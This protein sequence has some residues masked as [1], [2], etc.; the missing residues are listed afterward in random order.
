M[1]KETSS[2]QIKKKSA[3]SFRVLKLAP[4]DLSRS[5]DPLL[6]LS[7]ILLLG[8]VGPVVAGLGIPYVLFFIPKACKNSRRRRRVCI[9]SPRLESCHVLRD[10]RPGETKHA[11]GEYDGTEKGSRIHPDKSKRCL[12]QNVPR[13]RSQ[14]GRLGHPGADQ[15]RRRR[16]LQGLAR[17]PPGK[18]PRPEISDQF[19]AREN[20][21]RTS[22]SAR[23]PCRETARTLN[24]TVSQRT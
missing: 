23:P 19:A 4:F 11:T 18:D 7:Q 15:G 1:T 10:V 16:H 3:R 22:E 21:A 14:L 6:P 12:F 5:R 20:R 24:L 8:G 17:L 9:S 2:D 13:I